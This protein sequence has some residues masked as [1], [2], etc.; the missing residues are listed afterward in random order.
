[1]TAIFDS[2]AWIEYFAA[3]PKGER[4][5]EL[6]DG[7]GAKH[8]PAVCLLEIK[9]KYLREGHDPAERIDFICGSSSIV[10]ISKEICL[11]AADLRERHGLHT[12][13]AMVY[14]VARALKG[15]LYTCD[16]HFQKLDD[17]VV[18]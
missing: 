8:T 2:S 5:R 10:G 1:M 17:V 16:R 18:V 14:S 6:V 3:S 4:V 15:T 12:V 7:G 9:A 13:D 11:Q